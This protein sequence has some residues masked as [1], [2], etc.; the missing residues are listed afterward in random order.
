MYREPPTRQQRLRIAERGSASASRRRLLLAATTAGLAS[1]AAPSIQAQPATWPSR[2]LRIIVPFGPGGPADLSARALGELIGPDLGQPVIVENRPGG[3]SAVGVMAAAQARDGHT[4]LMGSNSMVINPLLNPS[5]SYSVAR[6]FDAIGMVSE[7]PLVMVVPASSTITTVDQF[8]RQARETGIALTAGNSGN[9][10]LAHLT[11]ELFSIQTSIPITSVAYKGEAALMP[12]LIES[13]IAFGFLNLPTVLPHLRSGRLRALAV[14]SAQVHP[15]LPQVP[16]LAQ[17]GFPA[18][19]V[20]GW[21]VLLAPSG[22]ID[23]GARERLSQRLA[24]ALRSDSLIQK[25]KTLGVAP[26]IRDPQATARHLAAEAERWQ[27]V[28]RSRGIKVEG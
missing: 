24:Q 16:T 7:Q 15:D 11:A 27:T 20:T 1:I 28:I 22:T 6:D 8:I 14:S 13:R 12:D 25:F 4:L 21:A 23:P 9:A 2:P 10:T 26:V 5:L 19:E 3:G 18:L 17:S